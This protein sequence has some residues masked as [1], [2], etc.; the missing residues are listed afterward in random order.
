MLERLN[1]RVLV[2]LKQRGRGNM[3]GL[4]IQNL[5]NLMEASAPFNRDQARREVV[6]YLKNNMAEVAAE[7]E[8]KGEAVILTPSGSFRL[9]KDDLVPA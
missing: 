2:N 6:D 9:T 7:L 5:L 1:V 3:G 4:Q 8:K